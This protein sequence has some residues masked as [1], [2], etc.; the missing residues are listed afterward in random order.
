M[1][2]EQTPKVVSG[3]TSD[4]PSRLQL[5]LL[6]LVTVVLALFFVY[7]ICSDS[8]AKAED[9]PLVIT[10]LFT[11]WI[12]A[13]DNPTAR[14]GVLSLCIDYSEY[15]TEIEANDMQE[16]DLQNFLDVLMPRDGTQVAG[17]E[18][19]AMMNNFVE[20][21]LMDEEGRPLYPRVGLAYKL[22]PNGVF[23]T[24]YT[25]GRLQPFSRYDEEYSDLWK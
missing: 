20:V 1:S 10:K 17:F 22:T 11:D 25:L 7:T 19:T 4:F 15:A 3:K 23:I 6:V 14:K 12:A 16:Q 21:T 2:T 5:S 24:D 18:V 8:Q 13:G 9:P